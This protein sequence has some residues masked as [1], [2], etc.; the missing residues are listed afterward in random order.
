[1]RRSPSRITRAGDFGFERSL[2]LSMEPSSRST[3]KSV[4]VPPVSMP[5]RT[6]QHRTKAS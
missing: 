1:M 4:K 2:K 3:M 5:M 6:I